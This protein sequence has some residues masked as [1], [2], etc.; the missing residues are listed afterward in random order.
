MRRH[1]APA[2]SDLEI[3]DRTHAVAM[4][5]WAI[6]LMQTPGEPRQSPAAMA[7]LLLGVP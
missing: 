6:R 2:S 1:C 3:L 4:F 5:A 7:R